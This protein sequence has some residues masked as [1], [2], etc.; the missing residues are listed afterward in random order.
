VIG[1]VFQSGQIEDHLGHLGGVSHFI[2]KRANLCT[3]S[4]LMQ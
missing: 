4:S 1:Q 3:F 2:G